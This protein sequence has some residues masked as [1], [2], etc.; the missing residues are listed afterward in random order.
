MNVS[1]VV[2]AKNEEKYIGNCLKML[3]K[4]TLKPEIIVVEGHSK[5]R[6]YQIA[7]KYAD[8]V[9]RDK[10]KGIADARNLGWKIAKNEII[11]YCDA[12]CLPPKDWVEKISKFMN[13][14]ICIFG[15]II[16]Y[17]GKLSVK[18]NLK[19]WGDLF[20]N[21]SSLVGYPCLCAANLAIKKEILKKYPFRLNFLEDF[22]LGDRIKKVGK[23]KFFRELYMPISPRRFEKGFFKVAF[24]YYLINYFKLKFKKKKLKTYW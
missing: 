21:I 11:A 24:K 17:E 14:N 20:L 2:C 16:P 7:K 22:D 19:I 15:P 5:D 3:R 9:V 4:Q 18:I 12:D 1:V 8:M 10:K 13:G 6:T 23:V